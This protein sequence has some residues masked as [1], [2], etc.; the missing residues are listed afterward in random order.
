MSSFRSAAFHL[1]VLAFLLFVNDATDALSFGSTRNYQRDPIA[2]FR[3]K[4]AFCRA[5]RTASTSTSSNTILRAATADEDGNVRADDVSSI[6]SFFMKRCDADGLMTRKDLEAVPEV[7]ELLKDGDLLMSELDD[8][9]NSAP[10]FPC[11]DN[12]ADQKIDVDSF[13]QIYR[14]IDDLF[15]D[16][17]AEENGDVEEKKGEASSEPTIPSTT[18]KDERELE[19][20][21]T[22]ICDSA[23]LISRENLLEWDEVKQLIDE[24]LLGVDEFNRIFDQTMKSP[25]T[26]MLDVEGFLSFNVYLDNLFEFEE[27][28]EDEEVEKASEISLLDIPEKPIITEESLPAG[29]LFADLA[30]ERLLVNYEEL[31]RWG[32]LR[33]MI[34]EGDLSQSELETMFASIQKPDPNS[35]AIGEEGFCELHEKIFDLFENEEEETVAIT[36][37]VITEEDLPAGVLFAELVNDSGVVGLEDLKRWGELMEMLSE[38]DITKNEINEMFASSTNVEVSQEYLDEEGFCRFHDSIFNLF[39]EDEEDEVSESIVIKAKLIELIRSLEQREALIGLECSEKDE[40]R[41][42]EVVKA[43]ESS[44]ENLLLK[45]EIQNID[46]AGSWDL[47]FTSSGMFKF[48]RGLT[49]LAG[50]V[51]NAEFGGLKQ[52]ITVDNFF[53]DL[54][55]IERINVNGS[56]EN[57]FDAKVNADWELKKSVSLFSGEPTVIM[58]VEPDKVTYGPTSTRADHWKSVRSMN[59][60]DISYLD[61]DLRIM[62]GNTSTDTVFVFKKA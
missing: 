15:E 13:T 39:E 57:S 60:L 42:L 22:S 6:Q 9:W 54:E 10:K 53:S 37:S 14:D 24:N 25:G 43:L 20:V 7:A 1:H 58:S 62:R 33:E 35:N 47:V 55:Y 40:S 29:V 59:L 38:G 19:D 28:E 23:G 45:R 16:D 56:D 12:E 32:E 51:P 50:S 8:I 4:V 2:S 3:S 11:G 18:E 26:D 61:S 17:F 36:K 48:N 5:P 30:N 49:G 41:V 31:S 34:S 21:F 46:I 44:P 27:E 52:I